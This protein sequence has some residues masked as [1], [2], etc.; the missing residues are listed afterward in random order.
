MTLKEILAEMEKEI[1]IAVLKENS[2][3]R[4][5]TAKKLG[6]SLVTLDKRITTYQCQDDL[7]YPLAPGKRGKK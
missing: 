1:I 7:T 6:I 2:W 3:H 5:N 4:R